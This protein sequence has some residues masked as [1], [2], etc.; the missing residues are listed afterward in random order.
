M[1][2][3]LNTVIFHGYVSHNQMVHVTAKNRLSHLWYHGMV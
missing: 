3:L 1:V 2:Y